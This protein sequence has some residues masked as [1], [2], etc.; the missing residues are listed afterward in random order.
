M[1]NHNLVQPSKRRQIPPLKRTRCDKDGACAGMGTSL[2]S[3]IHYWT[4]SLY[5]LKTMP[6][7]LIL[8]HANDVNSQ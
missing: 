8:T 4:H 2:L 5:R 7:L 3:L 6:T 1:R